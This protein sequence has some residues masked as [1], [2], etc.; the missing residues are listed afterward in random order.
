MSRR[1]RSIGAASLLVCLLVTGLWAPTSSRAATIISVPGDYPTIQAAIDAA[2]DGDTIR[3]S[4]GTYFETIDYDSKAITVESVAGPEGTIIDAGQSGPVATVVTMAATTG[5]TPVL[6]GFTIQNGYGFPDAGGID[7]TGGSPLIEGNR[8]IDNEG[9]TGVGIAARFSGATIRDNVI[10]RNR[11]VS[12][13]GGVGGGGIMVGGAG[14]VTIEG[15]TI[16]DNSSGS[17]GGIALASAGTPE[18]TDNIIRGNHGGGAGGGLYLINQSDALIVNN[19]IV[20]NDAAQGGGLAVLVP[21]SANGPAVINNT[22]VENHADVGAAIWTDG[23]HESS[24]YTNNVMIGA[25][26][27][28]T[29]ECVTSYRPTPP[30]ITFNDVYNTTGPAYAPACG[31]PTGTD[32][33]LSVDPRFVD[34]IAGDYHLRADSPLI[35][36]GSDTFAPTT[37][38]DG[39][40]RPHDGDED[41]TATVDIG[42]DEAIDPILLV[43]RTLAFEDSVATV[44]GPTL[45]IAF[46]NLGAGAVSVTSVSK[47]GTD[48]GDF[49]VTSDTCSGATM[50]VGASCSI[51]VRFS[52]TDVG[53]RTATVTFA[54][55]G[56]VGSRTVSLTGTGLDPVLVTPGSLAFGDVAMSTL[57]DPGLVSVVDYGDDPL[58]VSSVSI[59]G[60]NATDF[61]IASEDCTIAPIPVAMACSV[62][63]TF[64]PSVLGARSATLT[65]S[66]PGPVGTRTVPLAGTGTVPVSGVVWGG[67][68]FAGPAYTWNAGSALGTTSQSG[69]QRL[70]LAYATHRIGSKWAADAGPYAGI[71]YTRAVS[72]ATW[73]TPIRVN[74]TTQHAERVGLAASGSRVYVTWVTQT[75]VAR[76]SGTAPRVLYVRTNTNHGASTAWRTALRLTGTTGR[77]D[78]PTIAATGSDV[79]VAWTDAVAGTIKV[80]TSRNAG[81]TWTTRSIGSATTLT[82]D[83]RSGVPSV[84]AF[85]AT[86]AVVWI[87]DPAGTIKGRV[88]LDHGATWGPL[89]TIGVTPLGFASVAVRGNRVAVA[90][91]TLDDVVVRLRS[92]GT[93]GAPIAIASLEPGANPVP[94]AP[95]VVLQD[96]DRVGV[97]WSEELDAASRSNLRWTESTDGGATWYQTQTIATTSTTRGYNDWASVIWPTAGARSVVWNGWTANSSAFRLFFRKGTGTPTGLSVSATEWTPDT[98]PDL[99][100]DGVGGDGFTV[101]RG[102]IRALR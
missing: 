98:D 77:V 91:S 17:G 44:A 75:K 3:V 90:W 84:A 29:F 49:A 61:A 10:A 58:T 89:E 99:S 27:Q 32:A 22:F 35:D 4:P 1:P 21:G 55:P 81:T 24:R 62:G 42:Y 47:G 95:M 39:D 50:P 83:G 26:T 23:F 86:V 69:A 54:G 18:I 80:A 97:A 88:S 68:A 64:Q 8:I 14:T 57:S 60:P 51:S 102:P 63:V 11:Q 38:L 56:A 65:I 6:R 12:C 13:G 48:P 25:T 36:A 53:E 37:D 52:P 9:C 79:H 31:S 100:P 15:N 87:A 28:A 74:P 20:A 19:L 7:T 46:S 76:Y 78:Y 2:A 70:H 59:T 92:A 96:P 72:G 43:P 93:W 94:Y 73:S 71:Y 67:T 5:Q 66:G 40:T 16:E 85:G 45:P 82:T 33:N 101:V 41:G 30:V 34:P